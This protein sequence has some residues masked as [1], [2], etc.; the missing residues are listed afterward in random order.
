MIP[1][2]PKEADVIAAYKKL[3]GK[4]Q[5]KEVTTLKNG[6]RIIYFKAWKG[7]TSHP[8]VN[9]QGD[10]NFTMWIYC[11]KTH[12]CLGMI[13]EERRFFKYEKIGGARLWT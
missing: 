10:H 2:Y 1:I 8:Q 12:A 5:S 3:F 6:I 11:I 9:D 7:V 13:D 4:D